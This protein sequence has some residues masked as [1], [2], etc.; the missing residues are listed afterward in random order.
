[1]PK[2]LKIRVKDPYNLINSITVLADEKNLK[3]LYVNLNKRNLKCTHTSTTSEDDFT[4]ESICI[5]DGV[6]YSKE[7]Q[8]IVF[9]MDKDQDLWAFSTAHYDKYELLITGIR[10]GC[11]DDDDDIMHSSKKCSLWRTYVF[12]E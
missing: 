6:D 3:V 10:Y 5:G 1:M 8:I 11:K 12:K 2:K 4:S 9:N 7:A